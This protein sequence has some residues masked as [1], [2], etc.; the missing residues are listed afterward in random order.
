M[1]KMLRRRRRGK[2]RKRKRRKR[3]N[4]AEWHKP[5]ILAP[6]RQSHVELYELEANLVHIVNSRP[7]RAS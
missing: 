7:A 5:V 2:R 4:R 1:M 3:R 6:S